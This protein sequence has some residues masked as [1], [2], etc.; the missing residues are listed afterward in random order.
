MYQHIVVSVAPACGV[1]VPIRSH[2]QA[3]YV[4]RDGVCHVMR[5]A[6]SEKPSPL[7]PGPKVAREGHRNLAKSWPR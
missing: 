5:R 3:L 2:V 1:H 7:C 4:S 6:G